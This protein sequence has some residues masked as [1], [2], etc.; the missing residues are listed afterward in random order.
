MNQIYI[1]KKINKMKYVVGGFQESEISIGRKFKRLILVNENL[2]QSCLITVSY[3]H[4]DVYKRQVC[5][6]NLYSGYRDISAVET[7]TSLHL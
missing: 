7:E 4:L 3:T 6:G 2:Y 1:K 5:G